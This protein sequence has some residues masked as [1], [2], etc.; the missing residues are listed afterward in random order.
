MHPPNPIF[1]G[2]IRALICLL[3]IL[4]LVHGSVLTLSIEANSASAWFKEGIYAEYVFDSGSITFTNGTFSPFPKE[5]RARAT[6]RWESIYTKQNSTRLKATLSFRHEVRDS[7]FSTLLDVNFETREVS[8]PDGTYV[9]L[10]FLWLQ[11][12][13]EENQTITI[14]DGVIGNVTTLGLAST[15]QGLQEAFWVMGTGRVNGH[16]AAPGGGYDWDTGVLLESGFWG[17]PT[18][19]ALGILDPGV[20]GATEF[21]ATNI[22]LG[23]GK[24][25]PEESWNVPLEVSL[26]A[27]PVGTLALTLLAMSRRRGL[28]RKAARRGGSKVRL[29]DSE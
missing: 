18:L 17:E 5:A 29:L 1:F 26:M 8:V 28:T 20:V 13:P 24:P 25:D 27:I 9:G 15:P 7:C 12:K 3:V 23:S 21:T 4:S 16:T 22:D 6:F 2:F 10:T 14:T 19:V 11:P